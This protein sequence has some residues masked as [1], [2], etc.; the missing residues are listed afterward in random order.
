MENFRQESD[1]RK[2]GDKYIYVNY[3]MK[4]ENGILA[5]Y[6]GWGSE[7]YYLQDFRKSFTDYSIED[8]K[9][10]DLSIEKN[11]HEVFFLRI[12]IQL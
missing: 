11:Q 10:R 2:L 1:S 8:M 7:G 12:Y 9:H 5:V 3:K 6:E 4:Y